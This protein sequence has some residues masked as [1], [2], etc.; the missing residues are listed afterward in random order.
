MSNLVIAPVGAGGKVALYNGST[1]TVQLIA[2]VSGYVADPATQPIATVTNFNPPG[3]QVTKFDTDGNG[4]DAHD[5][6]LDFFG[7][8]YYVFGTSYSCGYQ[9]LVAGSPFCGPHASAASVRGT[10]TVSYR[11]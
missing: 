9:L 1:G 2:D 8:T 7:G 10:A 11:V 5:G 6:D 4:I 3:Q